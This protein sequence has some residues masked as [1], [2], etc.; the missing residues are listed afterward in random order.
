MSNY[1]RSG[2]GGAGNML[3]QKE[4][5][6][7]EKQIQKDLEAQGAPVNDQEYMDSL[8]RQKTKADTEAGWNDYRHKGRGGAGNYFVPSELSETGTFSHDTAASATELG[9]SVPTSGEMATQRPW[10]GRGGAGNWAA[11][12]EH[13]VAQQHGKDVKDVETGFGKEDVELVEGL[14]KPEQAHLKPVGVKK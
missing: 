14:K 4:L 10:R 1:I 12:E 9:S 8:S 7:R 2:R 5:E 3:T 6:E 11:D 13:V